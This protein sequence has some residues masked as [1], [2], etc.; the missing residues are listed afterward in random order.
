MQ[1]ILLGHAVVRPYAFEVRRTAIPNRSHR[2]K[3]NLLPQRITGR[4]LH[5]RPAGNSPAFFALS[6]A[7]SAKALREIVTF[8]GT[9]RI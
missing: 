4:F 9:A 3:G 2:F 1:F 6:T 8:E 5:E 7:L